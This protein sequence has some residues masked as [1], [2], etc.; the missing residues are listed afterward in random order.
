MKKYVLFLSALLLISCSHDGESSISWDTCIYGEE[1]AYVQ[2]AIVD[3]IC[4]EVAEKMNFI[5]EDERKYIIPTDNSNEEQREV[6]LF[7]YEVQNKMKAIPEFEKVSNA[8]FSYSYTSTTTVVINSDTVY[9]D[10][11]DTLI[12]VEPTG[13]T[14]F[15]IELYDKKTNRSYQ[16]SKML[17]FIYNSQHE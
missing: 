5:K 17:Y 10:S 3:S 9:S 15:S 1:N 4:Y 12:K 11:S 13:M 14:N 7:Y 16:C 6:D 2:Q 8:N